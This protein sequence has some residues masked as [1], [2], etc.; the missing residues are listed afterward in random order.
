MATLIAEQIGRD[1]LAQTVHNPFAF[2]RL[3]NQ[4]ARQRPGPPRPL[5]ADA[6][7]YLDRLERQYAE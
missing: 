1:A 3:Y 6:M 7:A 4:A 5:S 2:V